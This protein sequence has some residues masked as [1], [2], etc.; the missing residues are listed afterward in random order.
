MPPPG[1]RRQVLALR[2]VHFLLGHQAG[3]GLRHGVQPVKLQMHDLVLG[4]RAA[5]VMLGVSDLVLHIGDGGFVLV[6]LGLQLRNL[7]HRQQLALLHAAA[8]VHVELAHVAGFFGVHV[9]FLEGH[10]LRR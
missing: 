1:L 7:Q 2:V 5:Q 3:L 4:L 10:Q 6:Q 8:I 9:D